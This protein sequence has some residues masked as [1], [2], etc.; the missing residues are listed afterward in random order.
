M[1]TNWTHMRIARARAQVPNDEREM[2]SILYSFFFLHCM[3]LYLA[4]IDRAY[5]CFS[6]LTAQLQLDHIWKNMFCLLLLLLNMRGKH[7]EFSEEDLCSLCLF[8][9]PTLLIVY[10]KKDASGNFAC[11]YSSRVVFLLLLPLSIALWNGKSSTD[12]IIWTGRT[13]VSVNA[14][15]SRNEKWP[16]LRNLTMAETHFFKRRIRLVQCIIY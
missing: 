13:I 6:L 15:F 16:N 10:A 11:C 1:H 9:S 12:Q 4:I 5:H 3:L 14:L 8:S 7:T 2:F